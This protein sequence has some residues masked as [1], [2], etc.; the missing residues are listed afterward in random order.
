MYV[1]LKP[2]QAIKLY[3]FFKRNRENDMLF[4]NKIDDWLN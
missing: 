3:N 4:F 1:S 2:S